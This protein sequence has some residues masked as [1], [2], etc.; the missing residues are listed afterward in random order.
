MQFNSNPAKGT[1]I[2]FSEE[3]FARTSK[4]M[5]FLKSAVLF[6]DLFEIATIDTTTAAGELGQR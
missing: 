1:A 6:N 2:L 4:D 5:R 3:F